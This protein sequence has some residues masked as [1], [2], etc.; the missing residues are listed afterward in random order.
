MAFDKEELTQATL[1]TQGSDGRPLSEEDILAISPG[2][3]SD[4]VSDLVDAVEEE[5]WKN[6]SGLGVNEYFFFKNQY[7][8]IAKRYFLE[9]GEKVIKTFMEYQKIIEAAALKLVKEDKGGKFYGEQADGGDQ[10]L[11]RPITPDT[12]GEAEADRQKST[13][14]TG[15]QDAHLGP[16]TPSSNKAVDEQ[17]FLIFG[18][19]ISTDPSV[20][21]SAR[22]EVND[23]IGERP[24]VGIIENASMSDTQF[25]PKESVTYVQNDNQYQLNVIAAENAETDI[26]PVGVD[27]ITYD[28][29]GP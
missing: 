13:G 29:E 12:L 4:K 10:F 24:E 6:T 9:A 1:Q 20:V 8:Q 26:Y 16:V 7:D 27:I 22:D 5:E 2:T 19:L 14:G 11:L 21:I 25:I 28:Q 15:R 17:E 3:E 23:T 18:Y